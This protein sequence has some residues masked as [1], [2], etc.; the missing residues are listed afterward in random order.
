MKEHLIHG[1]NA[2][3]EALRQGLGVARVYIAAESRVRNFEEIKTLCRARQIP[4]DIVPLAKLNALTGA[5]DHQGLA[6]AVSPLA[7]AALAEVLAH[8]GPRALLLVLDHVQHPKN[9]GMMLRTAAA[10]GANAVLISARG[11]ARIDDSVVRASAGLALAVPVVLSRD[12]VTDFRRLRD[13]DFWI[14]GLDGAGEQNLFEISW[15]DRTALVIGNETEG[16]GHKTKKHCDA[17]V[18]IPLAPRVDSL[19]AAVAAGIALFQARA[20]GTA[21]RV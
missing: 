5:Q 20:G 9:L 8:C 4:C 11:G 18:H 19:N 10:A 15:P 13:H 21:P 14:Y 2:V 17:R 6:A 12:L 3:L 7:Y 16:L 1:A